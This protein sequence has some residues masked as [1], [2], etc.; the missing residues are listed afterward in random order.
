M[1]ISRHTYYTLVYPFL[2][3]ARPLVGTAD[4]KQLNY[5]HILHKKIV[6]LMTYNN[7]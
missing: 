1:L 2:A 6:R 3:Y 7:K 4:Q 5:I